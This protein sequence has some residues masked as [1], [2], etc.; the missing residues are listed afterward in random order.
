[1]VKSPQLRIVP[2]AWSLVAVAAMAALDRLAPLALPLPAP[3]RWAG[4]PLVLVGIGIGV[5]AVLLLR[6][7]GT[8]LRP[9][10]SPTVLVGRGP[11]RFSRHPMYLGLTL[12]LSGVALLLGSLSP[13]AVVLAFFLLVA[14]PTAISE[15]RLM[16]AA[17]GDAYSRQMERVRRWL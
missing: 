9:A 6:R 11:Y 4:L 1:M 2:G 3:C 14:R 10:R 15:E 8:T 16:L 7:D 17:F 13:W 5:W 12:A